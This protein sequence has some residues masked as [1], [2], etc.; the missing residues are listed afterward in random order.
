MFWE[1]CPHSLKQ[2]S[3]SSPKSW[4]GNWCSDPKTEE[5]DMI[6]NLEVL[7]TFIKSI[8]WQEKKDSCSYESHA[9]LT[10]LSVWSV[11]AFQENI[12]RSKRNQSCWDR[13]G[14]VWVCMCGWMEEFLQKGMASVHTAEPEGGICRARCIYFSLSSPPLYKYLCSLKIKLAS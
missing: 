9:R 3:S 4:R 10:A 7:I 13:G 11:S 5:Q 2:K 1:D 12:S 14:G 6:H 8:R